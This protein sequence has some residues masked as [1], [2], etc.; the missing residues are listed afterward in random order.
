MCVWICAC[1]RSCACACVLRSPYLRTAKVRKGLLA[2]VVEPKRFGRAEEFAHLAVSLIDNGYMNGE[3][4][5]MDAGLRF[6][7]L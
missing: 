3:V 2:Q 4:I 7:N 5:R 1:A 6:A